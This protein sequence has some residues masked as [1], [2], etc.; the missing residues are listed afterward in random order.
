MTQVVHLWGLDTAATEATTAATLDE[1]RRGGCDAVLHLSQ[2]LARTAKPPSLCIVT[3]GAQAVDAQETVCI[4]QAPLWGLGRVLAV[5]H[6]ELHCLLLDLEPQG[7]VDDLAA[8]LCDRGGEDQ[9]A[10]RGGRRFAP[11][12]ERVPPQTFA[13]PAK[14]GGRLAVPRGE[15]YRLELSGKGSLDC[16]TLRPARRRPPGAGEVEIEVR[17][18]GLNFSDVLKA[19][20][21]YPGLK[22]GAVPLGIEC[23][24][25]VVAVGEG[26]TDL[27]VGDEAV[28]LAAFSFAS[29]TT[30][31]AAA[32]VRK[33]ENVGFEEAAT[34]PITFSPPTTP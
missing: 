11:R 19:M 8:V 4:A 25:V 33:P 2:A 34:I 9:L 30:T 18:A 21:L 23:A 13:A 32:V 26:V 5:E 16:L 17:A 24:G 31:S 6:P 27:A 12:L 29:H 28:G 14:D 1:A 15:P 22:P 20:G 7:A 3:R 10:V